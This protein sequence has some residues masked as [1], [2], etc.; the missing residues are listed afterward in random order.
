VLVALSAALMLAATATRPNAQELYDNPLLQLWLPRLLSGHLADTLAW[1]RFEFAGLQPL[2]LLLVGLV[3]AVAAILA[4]R[5][6]DRVSRSV[7]VV[8]TAVLALLVIL[9]AVPAPGP[10]AWP[11]GRVAGG[12]EPAVRIVEAGAWRRTADDEDEMIMWAQLANAGAEAAGTRIE[13]RVTDAGSAT[14][15]A[16]KAWFGDVTIDAGE[17][18]RADLGWDLDGRDPGSYAW[19]VVVLDEA[20]GEELATSGPPRPFRAGVIP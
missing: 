17:R 7:A 13:Y 11:S 5:S 12:A 3:I 15:G 6:A 19:Q 16:W 1:R 20:T 14:D 4:T 10:S 2:A 18:R 8:G 9:V